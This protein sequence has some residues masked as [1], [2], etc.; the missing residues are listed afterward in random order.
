[1]IQQDAQ[2]CDSIS[3]TLLQA[4][5]TIYPRP[6]AGTREILQRI[7]ATLAKQHWGWS[8]NV[9][10]HDGVVQQWGTLMDERER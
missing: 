2:N 3:C 7:L 9:I 1:M 4:L 6:L 8:I 5:R 10:V